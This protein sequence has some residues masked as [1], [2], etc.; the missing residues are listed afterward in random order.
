MNEKPGHSR[1]GTWR[2]RMVQTVP[3]DTVSDFVDVKHLTYAI[4]YNENE[5]SSNN[6]KQERTR[7]FELWTGS[8]KKYYKK[9]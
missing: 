4:F 2:P 1:Q 5:D 7:S 3:S 8:K 9:Q 6:N